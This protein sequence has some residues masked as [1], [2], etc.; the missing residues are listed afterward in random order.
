MKASRLARVKGVWAIGNIRLSKGALR[1]D[2]AAPLVVSYSP[3][4]FPNP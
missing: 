4:T 1:V 3:Y 2:E